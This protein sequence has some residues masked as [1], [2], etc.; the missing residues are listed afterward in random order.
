ME[1]AL[2]ADKIDINEEAERMESHIAQMKDY[3]K[4]SEPAGRQMEFLLQEML[5]ETN[6]IGAKVSDIRVTKNVIKIKECIEKLR[7]Q[8]RNIE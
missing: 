1:V 3:L 8:V 5:R 4:S 6:T 7:E 2:F